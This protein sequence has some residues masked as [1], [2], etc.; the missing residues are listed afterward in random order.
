MKPWSDT[1]EGREAIAEI[2]ESDVFKEY[3]NNIGKEHL[4]LLASQLI[5]MNINESGSERKLMLL[6]AQYEGASHMLRSIKQ[7]LERERKSNAKS[8]I[9]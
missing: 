6:K 1:I 2:R 3:I 7:L 5:G 8:S 9:E 4:D